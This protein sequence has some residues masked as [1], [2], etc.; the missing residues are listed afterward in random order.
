MEIIL[1]EGLPKSHV[2]SNILG[3]TRV[4]T[5]VHMILRRYCEPHFLA[6]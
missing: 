3:I 2:H 4:A 1:I 5:K 6:H